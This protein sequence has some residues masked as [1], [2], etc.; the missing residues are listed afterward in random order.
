MSKNNGGQAFPIAA[1]TLDTTGHPML[2]VKDGM[3]LRDYF[4][5]AHLQ[6]V[7]SCAKSVI[8]IPAAASKKG[9]SSKEYIAW[10]SYVVADAMLAERDK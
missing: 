6:G 7:L 3:T 1:Y 2:M 10:A 8:E 5:A 4:A 9:M